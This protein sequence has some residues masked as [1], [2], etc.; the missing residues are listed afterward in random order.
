[1]SSD[2]SPNLIV[3]LGPTASGKTRF[4]VALARRLGGEIVSADSRQVFRGMD[5]GTGKDLGEYGE[6]PCHL[7]DI[8]DPGEPFSVFDFQRRFF[9]V[10]E[11]IR[12]RGRLPVLAGGTGMYLDAV[13]RGYRL[14][15][16]PQNA[17]LRAQLA[18]SSIEQLRER[19]RETGRQPHNTTDLIDRE[20]LIRAIEIAE[21]EKTADAVLPPLPQLRPLIFGIR[22]QR[23]ELRRRITVRLRERLAHGLIEEAQR[24]HASGVSW[25]TMEFYGLEYRYL[26]RHLR[27]EL[28]R[29][30]MF[31]KLNSAIHDFAKRQETWFRRMERQGTAIHWLDGDADPLADALRLLRDARLLSPT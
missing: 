23:E 8:L 21:G 29:N 1:M 19:L 17:P 18:G 27:G 4:A 6:I 9:A 3:V 24:L 26:A 5:I 22:R 2:S 12:G 11:E 25:E 14:V 15:E 16:V 31:Q 10:F 13:L 7:I 30:D 20:R 28:N